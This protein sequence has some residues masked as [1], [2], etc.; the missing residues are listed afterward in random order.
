MEY[1]YKLNS[2]PTMAEAHALHDQDIFL[3]SDMRFRPT[4]HSLVSD[5][6]KP[7][8]MQSIYEGIRSGKKS[9]AARSKSFKSNGSSQEVSDEIGKAVIDGAAEA[10]TSDE[11]KS[12]RR[13]GESDLA[14][15]QRTGGGANL[16]V[17]H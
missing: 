9:F 17:K 13:D 7:A 16:R 2:K 15:A 11:Q 6:H 14:W 3:K 10:C 8:K 4:Q 12:A 1:E 5:K